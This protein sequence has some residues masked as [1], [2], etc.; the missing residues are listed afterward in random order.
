MTMTLTKKDLQAWQENMLVLLSESQKSAILNRFGAELEP[1]AWTA[2]DIAEQIRIFLD[3]GYF[4]KPER[5]YGR[6]AP[7]L[8]SGVDF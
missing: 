7:P 2:Q 8:P 4:V 3:H 5:S 6:E 1:Y